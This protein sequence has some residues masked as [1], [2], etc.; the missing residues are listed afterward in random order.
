M[1]FVL[2]NNT[3]VPSQILERYAEEGAAVVDPESGG[4]LPCPLVLEDL[5]QSGP[6]VRH[7]GRKTALALQAL[8]ARERVDTRAS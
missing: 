5:L 3:P 1:S 8:F 4:S 7:D 2:A 6:V